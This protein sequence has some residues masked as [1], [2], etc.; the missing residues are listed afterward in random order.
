MLLFMLHGITLP[1]PTVIREWA[2]DP[3]EASH[4]DLTCLRNSNTLYPRHICV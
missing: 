4:L 2:P 3:I 1:V